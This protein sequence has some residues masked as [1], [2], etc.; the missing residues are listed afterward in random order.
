MILHD[1]RCAISELHPNTPGGPLEGPGS[2]GTPCPKFRNMGLV[3]GVGGQQNAEK[4]A[5]ACGF[6]QKWTLRKVRAAAS[7]L[8]HPVLSVG[9][10]HGSRACVLS[11]SRCVRLRDPMDCGQPGFSVH[12]VSQARIL[13]PGDLSG[14][15][16]KPA[17]LKSPALAGRFFTRQ[18]HLGSLP[19][20]LTLYV[21]SK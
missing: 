20:S 1:I 12:G 7:P 4:R 19:V 14:P 13:D 3:T 11:S 2:R 15:G 5:T 6:V 16:I 9:P 8:P 17:S 18:H 10:Q 21:M